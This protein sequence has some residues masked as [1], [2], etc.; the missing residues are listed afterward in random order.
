MTRHP[1]FSPAN[2][3]ITIL[4]ATGIAAASSGKAGGLLATWARPACIVPLSYRLHKELAEEHN[5]ATRW[6]Y[7]AVHCGSITAT[8]QDLDGGSAPQ[9]DQGLKSG[10]PK[11]R[12]QEKGRTGGVPDGL[13]WIDEGAITSYSEEGN[14]S[15]TAQVHPFLFTTSMADLA[16]EAGAKIVLGRATSIERTEG[17]VTG[18]KYEGNITG[19]EE[20]LD[21]TDVV[22]SAGPWTTH[23]WPEL[24]MDAARVHSVVVE[25]KVSAYA[26]F[27]EIALPKGWAGSKSQKSVGP[28]MYAHHFPS[29]LFASCKFTV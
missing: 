18:V 29:R 9:V 8:A 12:N 24:E 23:I 5:G 22:L 26:V 27:T 6:G 15:T 25:A 2:T 20:R 4:E 10:L 16:R 3:T 21:A 28:E 13:D 1:S 17:G 19:K 14:P 11:K 7:R